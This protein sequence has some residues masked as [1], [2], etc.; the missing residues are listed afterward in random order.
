M[1]VKMK[2]ETKNAIINGKKMKQGN[3]GITLIALVITII[4]LL[5]LA[6]ISIALLTG[7]NGILTRAS[8]SKVQNEE[9]QAIESINL[10]L[11]A[12]KTDVLAKKSTNSVYDPSSD[13]AL[14]SD[15]TTGLDTTSGSKNSIEHT[16]SRITITYTNASSAISVFGYIDLSDP[17]HGG[18]IYPAPH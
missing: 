4:V 2:K 6:G 17:S 14:I 9:K 18:T 10:A 8:S 3:H 15:S 13:N 12:I 5:I 7:E 1:R 16:G 11:N